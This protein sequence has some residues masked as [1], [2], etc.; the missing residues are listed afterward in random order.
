MLRTVMKAT[1]WLIP[2]AIASVSCGGDK[3]K[4]RPL[5]SE[6][7]GKAGVAT[8]AG[9]PAGKPERDAFH[10]CS[11]IKE[12]EACKAQGGTWK[13]FVRMSGETTYSCECP[14]P[15]EGCPCEKSS[16]CMSA[17]LV[18][19]VGSNVRC[20]AATEGQCGRSALGCQCILDDK[21]KAGNLCAD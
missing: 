19:G 14:V 12:A 8:R 18:P 3:A 1:S 7:S 13:G 4:D 16:D 17:C 11:I 2:I 5:G 6:S 15:D 21:G 10:A 9:C 20:T